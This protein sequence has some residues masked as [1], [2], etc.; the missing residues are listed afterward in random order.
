[1]KFSFVNNQWKFAFMSVHF[2][3]ERTI[4]NVYWLSYSLSFNGIKIIPVVR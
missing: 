1:M 2:V 3:L 4:S